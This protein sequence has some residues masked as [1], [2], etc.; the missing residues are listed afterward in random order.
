MNSGIKGYARVNLD[1]QSIRMLQS[2]I[3]TI[4]NQLDR[5]YFWSILFDNI[6]LGNMNPKK[7]VE[8]FI[9]E[10]MNEDEQQTLQFLIDKTNYIMEYLLKDGQKEHLSK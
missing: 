7:F 5:T 10:I 8:M 2:K 3:G 9:N 6:K 4:E 1:E